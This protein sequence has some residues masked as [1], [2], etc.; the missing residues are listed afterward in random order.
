MFHL[1]KVIS[2]TRKTFNQIL[3]NEED[4][5]PMDVMDI[6]YYNPTFSF[7]FDKPL[8]ECIELNHKYHIS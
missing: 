3:I 2:P 8:E 7:F 4:S 6:Q 5:G 1:G